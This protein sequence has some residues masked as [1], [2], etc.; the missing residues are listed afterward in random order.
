MINAFY[1]RSTPWVC[2]KIEA[3]GG[4]HNGE[5]EEMSAPGEAKPPIC[6][7][8]ATTRN[9]STKNPKR[10]AEEKNVHNEKK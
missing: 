5:K 2:G 7:L 8:R 1:P 3:V 4:G 6:P 9:A 10:T